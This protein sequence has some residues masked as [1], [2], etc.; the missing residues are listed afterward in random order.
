MLWAASAYAMGIAAGSYMWRPPL[1]WL[2]ATMVCL[3][4]AVCILRRRGRTAY[5]LSLGALLATGSLAIQVRTPAATGSGVLMFADGRE[6]TITAHVIREGN[7]REQGH[8]E[9]QQKLDIETE[10]VSNEDGTVAARSGVRVSFYGK[11]AAGDSGVGD[12]P[13]PTHQFRYGERL[14]FPAKL[15]PPRNF[16]NPGAF[17]YREYLTD[18]GIVALGSA[19]ADQVEL[20]PGFSGNRFE[21]V[22]SRLRRRLVE[23]IHLLWPGEEASL[24][25]AILLGEN[26]FLGRETITDFQRTGTY[27]VLVVSGLKVAILALVL[28]W[29]L[30]RMRVND[31]LAS[32]FTVLLV[33][34]Y[35][36]VTGVG[37]PV[38]R[39]AL[40]LMIYLG[41]RLL[42]RHKSVLN[43]IGAAALV[44]LI[45]DPEALLGSSFQ[46]SFLCVLAIARIDSPLLERSTQPIRRAF[47][48]LRLKSLDP[49]FSPQLAALRLKANMVFDHL[50][51]FTR[52]RLPVVV[53]SGTVRMLVLGLEFLVISAVL[54]VGLALPMA[55]YFH[56]ATLVSLPANV[57]AVPLTEISVVAAIV[58]LVFSFVWLPLARFPALIAGLALHAMDGS[59]RWLGKLQIADTRVP[60]PQLV[61]ILFG[62]GALVLAMLLS[63][64]RWLLVGAGWLALAASAVWICAVPPRPEVQPGVLEMTTIDVGQGDSILL[65]SPQ[66]RTLLVDGGGTPA[67]MHSDLDIGEDVVSPYLWSRGMHQLDAVALTHAH[68]DHMG[69][70]AAVLANF[71]PRELWL[72]VDA[73][74]AQPLEREAQALGISVI[75]RHSGDI[76]EFGGAKV[77]VLPPPPDLE[78]R[79]SR[80]NDESLVMKVSYGNT[81]ALLEG[82]AEKKTERLVADEDPQA[83]LLKVAH[84]GSA[85]STIP[86]LLTAVHPRYAVISVGARNSMDTRGRKS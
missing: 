16:R 78:E 81:S 56:R 57:L 65:I 73:P 20:L 46:L 85:T 76:V 68:A 72:G 4:S 50:Q 13:A 41:A 31:V 71:H 14:R 2:V 83:D 11:D 70:L 53:L 7:L 12:A 66:G 43:A 3:I 63:R 69:G 48:N 64:R 35:A 49:L 19:K 77:A 79:T 75:F 18:A 60:T 59:V 28:F 26:S 51:S 27:H 21:R 22:R 42:Y 40:M 33:I 29:L 30:R 86:E 5:A 17:D 61:V 34:A 47:T 24:L 8:G 9:T 37:A 45:V 55:Y 80:A 62:A 23:R 39:A 67:W 52:S 32:A 44:L 25:N 54:Q 10:Q 84:H 36:I 6:I 38:W 82:D 15:Y 58:A 1:W 74:G